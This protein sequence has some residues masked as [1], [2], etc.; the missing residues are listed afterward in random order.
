M[1][2]EVGLGQPGLLEEGTSLSWRKTPLGAQSATHAEGRT[3][4]LGRKA[5]KKR[6][7]NFWLKNWRAFL[8]AQ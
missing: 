1:L 7:Q 3:A 6:A 5:A 8:V 2:A 4:G